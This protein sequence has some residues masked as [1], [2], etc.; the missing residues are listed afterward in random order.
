MIKF[1]IHFIPD[2]TKLDFLGKRWGAF[3]LST[4]LI[5]ASIALISIKGLN[6][7]IDFTGGIVIEIR[8]ENTV[9][10]GELRPKIEQAINGDVALQS[11]G[12][13]NDILIRIQDTSNTENA[14]Q[15]EMV[16]SV[17]QIITDNIA[18]EI[19]F[20]KVDFVGPQISSE[21]I[22]S[23]AI[24]LSL[25]IGAILFYIWMRFEI[26]F[27][28]GAVVALIHDVILT[29]GFMSL[30]SLEFNLPSIAAILTIIGYS[31]NDSVVIFDRIRENLRK[32]KTKLLDDILN[33]SI[34]D[35]LSRTILT[36]GTTV[37][38]L[39]ALVLFGGSVIHGFSLSVLFGVII[40]TYSSIYVAAPVL[41]YMGLRTDNEN[42]D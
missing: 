24:S 37:A 32:Y 19:D 31:I 14:K 13:N 11:F 34:N 18:G 23:G 36:G 2:D 33:L 20:R 22:S 41:I 9:N 17:K 39:L 10:I 29:L 6:F 40:G 28:I 35:T 21:L 7:G 30:I 16:A 26:Q 4:I 25:A 5:L 1:P 42:N 8:T 15:S 12:E 38:A 3:V 27:G